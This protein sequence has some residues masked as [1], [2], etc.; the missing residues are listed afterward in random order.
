MYKLMMT[1]VV[2]QNIRSKQFYSFDFSRRIA[3]T[4]TGHLNPSMYDRPR[5]A[6]GRAGGVCGRRSLRPARGFGRYNPRGNFEFLLCFRRVLAHSG[7]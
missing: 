5:T 6:Y 2:N 1:S 4:S 3:L 7:T